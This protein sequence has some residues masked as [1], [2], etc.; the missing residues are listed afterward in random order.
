[1]HLYLITGTLV[2]ALGL[3]AT[4]TMISLNPIADAFV[5][6]GSVHPNAGVPTMNY[7]GAGALQVSAAGTTK[8][9]MQSLL[10]FDFSTAKS[11]FDTTY[12]AGNWIFQSITFQLG[13]NFGTQGTQPNNP[14]FNTINAGLFQIDWLANDNW[15]EGS[16]TPALPFE[17]SSSPVDGVTFASLGSLISAADRSLG[18]FSYVPVGNTNPPSIPPALYNLELNPDFLIDASAGNSVSFRVFAADSTVSY[19]FNSRSF[20]GSTRPGLIVEAVPEPGMPSIL[21]GGAFFQL[22][23][24]RRDAKRK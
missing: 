15:G 7:G 21:A 11:S 10:R 5:T 4:A 9:E 16:G 23:K 22:L 17:P 13:T 8:G 14:I 6:G 2:I 1:M 19:L 3:P 24:R 20:G 18:T 12:G